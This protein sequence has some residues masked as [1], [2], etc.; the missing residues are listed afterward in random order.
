M[1]HTR[2]ILACSFCFAAV[3]AACSDDGSETPS[4][5]MVV[6]TYNGGL[7]VGF[8]EA[9]DA[10]APKT[11]E[12][13]AGIGADVLCV[14]E[15]WRAQD[16]ELLKAA[17]AS[18]LPNTIFP[19]PDPG[20]TGGVPCEPGATDALLQ[21]IQT[22][23]CD[24]VC[25]D[26]LIGC[27]LDNCAAEVFGLPS[28]CRT[29]IQANVGKEL[30]DILTTCLAPAIEY[31]YGGSFGIGLLSAYPIKAQETKLFESTTNR[32]A[33]IYALLDTPLGD[34][35]TFC[36]HLTAVFDAIE[37]PK[38]TGSWEEEQALQ[39]EQLVAWANEKAG[40]DGQV[41]LMGDMNTGPAG[42][43]Y[44]AEVP[45]HY[46]KFLAA[47]FDNPYIAQ[48]GHLCTFCADNPIIARGSDDKTSEVIDHVLM[49][50]FQGVTTSAKR[51]VDQ[52]LEVENC[53][54]TLQSAYSDHF[55]VSVTISKR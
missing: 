28:S 1:L 41:L 16:V 25:A 43:G 18:K 45:T 35:H 42:D 55:A 17:T 52:G 34:V 12:A 9:A 24:K 26:E 51:A 11:A 30:D 27:G 29:C 4:S 8:V 7:A 50:G 48:P 19:P 22:N 37:Y 38:G 3:V 14:Q 53:G 13:A 44:V 54:K 21:C 23:G 40:S 33:G 6:A 39:V 10:R 46:E 47:G 36:T 5:R 20:P 15:F 2:R 32:R 31:A 49:R